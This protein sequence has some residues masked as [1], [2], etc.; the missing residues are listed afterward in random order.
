[1]FIILAILQNQGGIKMIKQ[2][3]RI[4]NAI[5]KKYRKYEEERKTR[6]KHYMNS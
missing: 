1:M 2:F 6:R 3:F 4:I 5:I